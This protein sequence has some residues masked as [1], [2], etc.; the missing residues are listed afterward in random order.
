MIPMLADSSKRGSRSGRR[1]L[2]DRA[3]CIVWTA[4]AL[5]GWAVALMALVAAPGIR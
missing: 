2:S 3:F 4:A 1:R 5:T